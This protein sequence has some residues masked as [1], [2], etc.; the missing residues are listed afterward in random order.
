MAQLSSAR[1]AG[2]TPPQANQ[3]EYLRLLQIIRRRSALPS[4]LCYRKCWSNQASVREM[5][6][7]GRNDRADWLPYARYRLVNQAMAVSGVCVSFPKLYVRRQT[8]FRPLYGSM[9]ASW[10]VS[11]LDLG[12][13]QP[14]ALAPPHGIFQ[15]ESCTDMVAGFLFSSHAQIYIDMH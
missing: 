1:R 7:Q 10:P 4:F 14:T 12:E 15:I 11:L 5:Q 8:C 6:G 2:R 3:N 13:S 9:L